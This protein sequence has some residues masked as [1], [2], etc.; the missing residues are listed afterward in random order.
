M[1]IRQKILVVR[2]IDN[3]IHDLTVCNSMLLGLKNTSDLFLNWS[4]SN[5]LKLEAFI[6]PIS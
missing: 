6:S 3:I 4:I 2:S 5:S 1:S